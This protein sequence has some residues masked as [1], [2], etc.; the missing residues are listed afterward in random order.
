M[1]YVIHVL[2]EGFFI[3]ELLSFLFFFSSAVPLDLKDE[4]SDF[5]FFY[6]LVFLYKIVSAS[7]CILY[8]LWYATVT[9]VVC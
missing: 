2:R 3:L 6:L 7:V 1:A 8:I 5:F 4:T 9:S